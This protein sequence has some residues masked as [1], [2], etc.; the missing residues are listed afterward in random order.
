[1]NTTFDIMFIFLLE[2]TYKPKQENSFPLS[3]FNLHEINPRTS[4]PIEGTVTSV[5]EADL[6]TI[7][8]TVSAIDR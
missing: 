8:G 6:S 4:F 3:I 5:F 1:M 7:Y 2:V